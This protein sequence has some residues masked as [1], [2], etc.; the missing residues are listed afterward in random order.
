MC[1]TGNVE[2]DR[3]AVASL[4]KLSGKMADVNKANVPEK[5][6]E[7]VKAEREMKKAA[8]AL[9]KAKAK[10]VKVQDNKDTSNNK[11]TLPDNIKH[12]QSSETLE[13]VTNKNN[14]EVQDKTP[15]IDKSS[16]TSAKNA[17]LESSN[18]EKSKAKL[19]A[20]RRAKQEAQR[21]AKQ[22]LLQEKSKVK[23]KESRN[24]RSIR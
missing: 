14:V 7:E 10:T 19:R 23:S 2:H 8:K 16:N 21:A 1:F 20:E 13:S 12:K 3:P 9:A 15:V 18:E 17:P 5:T 4:L 11:S 24:D 22:Q 6:R